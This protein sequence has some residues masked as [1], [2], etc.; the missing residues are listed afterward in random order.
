M[1]ARQIYILFFEKHE[2]QIF[3]SAKVDALKLRAFMHFPIGLMWKSG[4]N[5]KKN[6]TKKQFMN[7]I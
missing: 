3:I 2:I 5:L 7:F 4:K 1:K 6:V